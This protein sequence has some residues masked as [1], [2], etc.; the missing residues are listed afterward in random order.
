MRT[1]RLDVE[2]FILVGGASSRMGSDK[3][4]LL[5]DGKTTMTR[6]TEALRPVASK[7]SMVGTSSDATSSSLR[8]IPDLHDRWGPL[9]GIQ[10]ALRACETASC[11]IIACDLP[12][13]TSELFAYLLRIADEQ[14][15]TLEAVVPLQSD[16]RPQ[17]LCAVYK[18][19]PCLMAAEKS[20]AL[21]EHTPRAML[22]KVKTRYVNFSEIANLTGS[23]HFFFNLNRPDD[24]ERA[25]EIARQ[26][27]SRHDD[28]PQVTA[29]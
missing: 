28:N 13:L 24:Y 11:L 23:E 6:I 22:D 7:V 4:Q 26:Q 16:G 3:S 21:N 8:G 12:F 9:G 18:R 20:I 17:P 10:A 15:E 1:P 25:K 29:P 27:R 19:V 2:G 14:E 5:L